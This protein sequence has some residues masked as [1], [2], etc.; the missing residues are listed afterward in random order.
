M[1][2]QDLITFIDRLRALPAESEWLEFKRNHADSQEIG[3]P[4]GPSSCRSIS[5]SSAVALGESAN[6]DSG[7]SSR[8][9]VNPSA[10]HGGRATE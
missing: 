6:P 7:P 3:V 8:C 1:S 2:I 4:L 9:A 5:E 10:S